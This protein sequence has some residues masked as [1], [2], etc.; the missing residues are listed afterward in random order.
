MVEQTHSGIKK[1]AS[2]RLR[3]GMFIHD[4]DCGW[5]DHPFARSQF[6]ITDTA[7][8]RT[9]RDHGIREVY[10]DIRKGIDDREA[11][12]QEEVQRELQ[13]KLGQ[14]RHQRS[15]LS[16]EPLAD[17]T[18]TSLREERRTAERI[19][20]ESSIL[21][22]ELM[23]EVKLGRQIET[24]RVE[25]VVGKMV[26]SVF[27]N[28]DAMLSLQRVRDRDHYTYQHSV[29][30]AVLLVVFAKE[31][32]VGRDTIQELGIGGLLHDIGKIL[33]P[34]E[35]LNKPGKL[36]DDE[37]DTMRRHVE[38][39]VDILGK[40]PGVSSA[41]VAVVAQHHERSDGAGY[42][43]HLNG[44]KISR[45]GQ[46]ASI[47]DVYDAL[48]SDR[49]YHQGQEPTEVMR[50]LLEWSDHHFNP[51]LVQ[52][53]IRCVGIYP[54]GTLVRLLSG[55]LAVVIERGE[56]G[57]LYPTVCAVYDAVHKEFIEPIDID[58]SKAANGEERIM[59]FASPR[60]WGIEPG[61]FM[62]S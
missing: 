35:I 45:Y 1:I 39:G 8:I 51:K 32:G 13:Q 33:V 19:I 37:F 41:A 42:P 44:E 54:V 31:L 56:K 48:T 7:T 16:H 34:D 6:F 61:R 3:P 5:L 25:A 12:P 24:E 47:V 58:L 20:Q 53:F 23:G 14:L 29:G 28:Q 30:V 52:Q 9:I 10:I 18:P 4:L 2:T 38:F 46:M 36:S 50:K 11:Q 57:P 62:A 40:T 27:R 15:P 17:E 55:R 49:I 22:T 59:A 21:V 43:N 60:E 26:S